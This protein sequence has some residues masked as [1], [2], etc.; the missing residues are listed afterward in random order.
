MGAF[1]RRLTRKG[2]KYRSSDKIEIVR[3]TDEGE[4]ESER[5]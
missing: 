2:E 5:E 3:E 4:R 1:K